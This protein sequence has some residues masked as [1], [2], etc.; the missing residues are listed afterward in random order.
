[1]PVQRQ[2]HAA[3]TSKVTLSESAELYFVPH[4]CSRERWIDCITECSSLPT[5]RLR[6][7]SH[8]TH[9]SRTVNTPH[10][11]FACRR[12]CLV[13]T[14]QVRLHAITKQQPSPTPLHG[15][16][17]KHRHHVPNTSILRCWAVLIKKN[18]DRQRAFSLSSSKCTNDVAPI[19]SARELLTV[20]HVLTLAPQHVPECNLPSKPAP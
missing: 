7:T 3:S 14:G 12:N 1:L 16:T 9:D 15:A 11:P 17:T 8:A 10:P 19:G 5:K 18:C 6:H 13:N 20:L 4:H 2:Y